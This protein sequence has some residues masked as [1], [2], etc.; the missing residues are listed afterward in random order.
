MIMEDTEK[1]QVIKEIKHQFMTYRNGIVADTLRK[2]GMPYNVVFGLQL[3]Q[4]SQIAIA[5]KGLVSQENLGVVA[6]DLWS[7]RSVRESR[8]L[9]CWL[10][11]AASLSNEMALRLAEDV[12]TREEADILCFRLLRRL[13]YASDLVLTLKEDGRDL[14]AY[15]GEALARN[16][17]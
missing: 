5:V 13:S 3:P 11:D 7:D 12:Q 1:K 14:V 8:L 17:E 16:L 9:A 4:L 10:Y 2:A 15:C 6:D